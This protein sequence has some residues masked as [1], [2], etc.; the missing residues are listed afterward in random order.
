MKNQKLAY[1]Y[2]GSA[3]F[4]W[5][6]VASAFKIALRYLS[7][8]ELLF[9]ASVSSAAILF[10]ALAL[11]GDVKSAFKFDKKSAVV[12][13]FA[14]LLNPT[15]Y[16]IVL[17]YAYDLL[18]A[19]IAQPLNYTWPILLVL[20]SALFLKQKISKISYV[21]ILISFFGALV[22]SASG[23]FTSEKISAPGVMLALLSAVIWAAFWIINMKDKRPAKAK[24]FQ[25]FLIGSLFVF[26]ITF[27]MHG[28][29][30]FPLKGVLAA[31]Y[32]GFF[33]MGITYLL[34]LK[35]LTLSENAAKV[36]NLV[37]IAPFLSLLFIHI[38]VGEKI[39]LTTFIGLSLI[40]L[41]IILES[42]ASAK[43]T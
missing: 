23:H 39:F 9:I 43:R 21:S 3:V 28:F 14:A 25:N 24:L 1:F 18:P 10:F 33:E 37:Y 6:T 5:S 17:F 13:L 30:Q 19:Q 32:V 8:L 36:G 12:A 29:G 2:I 41:G 31:I 15:A 7:P 35:A 42:S 38:I 4:L 26:I 40:V 27:K 20:F 22:I 11:S 16:Y 34:F